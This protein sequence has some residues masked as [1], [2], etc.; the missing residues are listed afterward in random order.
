MMASVLSSISACISSCFAI[1]SSMLSTFT[2]LLSCSATVWPAARLLQKSA[3]EMLD[4]IIILCWSS[5]ICWAS[6]FETSFSSIFLRRSSISAP[7]QS[8]AFFFCRAAAT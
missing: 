6:S 5:T 2:F 7:L 4:S 3:S 1:I 8:P